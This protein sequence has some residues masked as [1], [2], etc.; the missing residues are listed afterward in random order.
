MRRRSRI[1]V[2]AAAIAVVAL[3][4]MLSV[5]AS[6]TPSTTHGS[7]LAPVTKI[8]FKLDSHS[9]VEG[10]AVTGSVLVRTRSGHQWVGLASASLSLRVDGVEVATLATDANGA[11]S[12]SYVGVVGD[13]VMKVVFTGDE[14]HKRAQRAQGFEVAGA[15]PSPSPSPSES[16]S[17]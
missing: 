4:S 2:P 11:A 16:P 14:L 8:A 3:V 5:G 17:P 1:L 7:K 9:V 6:A 13:H 15:A 12:V 10:A